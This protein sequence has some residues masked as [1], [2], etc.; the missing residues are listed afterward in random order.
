MSQSIK[1]VAAVDKMAYTVFP[2]INMRQA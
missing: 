1:E 2:T